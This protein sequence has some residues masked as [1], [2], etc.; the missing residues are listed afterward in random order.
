MAA[1]ILFSENV[2]FKPLLCFLAM[3]CFPED[4]SIVLVQK[5]ELLSKYNKK[6]HTESRAESYSRTTDMNAFSK[7]AV[8]KTI[9]YRR[10]VQKKGKGCN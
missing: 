8:D 1:P 10:K 9:K 2:Y 5:T 6:S 3:A 7:I 4:M